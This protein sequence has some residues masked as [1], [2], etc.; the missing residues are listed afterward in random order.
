[1][2][3]GICGRSIGTQSQGNDGNIFWK[4]RGYRAMP[5]PRYVGHSVKMQEYSH[6]VM[7]TYDPYYV[8]DYKNLSNFAFDIP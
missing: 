4:R 8:L 6:K 2:N 7:F 3:S 1:M 5:F